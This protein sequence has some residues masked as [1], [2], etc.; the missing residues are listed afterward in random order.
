MPTM[1]MV[2]DKLVQRVGDEA[3]GRKIM[4]VAGPLTGVVA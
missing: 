3:K 2:V 4:L 1:G